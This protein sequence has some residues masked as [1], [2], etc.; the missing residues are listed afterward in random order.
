[1]FVSASLLMSCG[2]S[3][4]GCG[5][6]YDA[7]GNFI[8]GVC[9]GGGPLT[10]FQLDSINVCAGPPASPTPTPSGTVS[11]TPTPT[12]C[13][14]ATSTSVAAGDVIQF[15]ADGLFSKKTQT[16]VMD[17]TDNKQTNW[18]TSNSASLLPPTQGSGGS[19]TGV[20]PGCACIAA[21]AGGISSLQV[22]IT[23]YPTAG[24]TPSCPPCPTPLPTAAPAALKASAAVSTVSTDSSPAGVM[25]WSFDA[26]AT[27]SGSVAGAPD[28]TAYF[29]TSDSTLQAVSS[30]GAAK[31][32]TLASGDS[33]AVSADGSLVYYRGP[34]G[35]LKALSPDG[36]YQWGSDMVLSQGPLAVSGSTVF[37]VSR[38]GQLIAIT[39][40]GMVLWQVPI[41]G[42]A[43]QAVAL[44]D[45]GVIAAISRGAVVAV[46]AEGA[47]RW[48]F[49]PDGGFAGTLAVQDGV[50]YVG[51][52]SGTV[53][54]L[55]ASS[56]AESWHYD[57]GTPIVAG[58]VVDGKGTIFF[59]SGSLYALGPDGAVRWSNPLLPSGSVVLAGTPSG[60]FVSTA[61]G[62]STEYS[63]AGAE[64]WTTR[65]F[66]TAVSATFAPPG[67]LYVANSSGRVFAVR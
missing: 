47:V 40:P 63:D 52:E 55:D 8:P 58:P 28:A 67:V 62:S 10:G 3:G 51:S 16:M 1:M 37:A 5:G 43:S 36:K 48:S 6:Y 9:P 53:Y 27:L 61:G 23:V 24:A 18:T 33:V 31:W 14:Q 25:Q 11:P 17:I 12:M 46:S 65:D 26:G 15:H 66:A 45:G 2:G 35:K 34:D 39:S 38:D 32:H 49:T 54:A 29:A 30:T 44:A 41:G 50:V 4:L 42:A 64:Q 19:Y 22:G 21:T 20:Q 13:P 59:A 7:F 60:V 57:S 56:G